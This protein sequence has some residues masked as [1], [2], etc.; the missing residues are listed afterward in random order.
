[1]SLLY[2]VFSAAWW[3]G[4]KHTFLGYLL[5]ASH[6]QIFKYPAEPVSEL[7]G[8]HKQRLKVGLGWRAAAGKHDCG[9]DHFLNQYANPGSG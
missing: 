7:H 6:I 9:N 1:M 5:V 2:K 4:S 8:F 3:W